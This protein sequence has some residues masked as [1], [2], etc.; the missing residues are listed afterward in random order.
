[1][2]LQP[3]H[4]V[5]QEPVGLGLVGGL[6]LTARDGGEVQ[7]RG[8]VRQRRA[9]LF[10]RAGEA[11]EHFVGL[12]LVLEVRR[13]ER[14]DEV[15]IEITGRHGGR[16]FI[17]G[18]EEEISLSCRLALQPFQL[19]LPYPVAGDI[20]VIGALHDPFQGLVVV[21]IELGGIEALGALLDARVEVVGLLEIQIEL[22]VV[23]IKGD[24][25]AA[26]GLEDRPQDR[27]HLG[28][29]VIG[30]VSAQLLDGGLVETERIAQLF[31]R[32]AQRG[33]R[34]LRSSAGGPRARE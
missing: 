25:L 18:A 30:W 8:V 29:E 32:G 10:V 14:L 2:L 6:G 5:P 12:L 9:E 7:R 16:A 15:E 33:M 31:G 17:G 22:P 4:Q 26:D 28:T 1:M 23:R 11:K 19:V 27:F 20:S 34:C 13:I 21:A 24:E 3:A